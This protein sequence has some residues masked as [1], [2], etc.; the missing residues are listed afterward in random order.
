MASGVPS[1]LN[2]GR[3]PGVSVLNRQATSILLKFAALIWSSG[4]Y[5]VPWASAG[6]CV[7]S[8]LLVVGMPVVWPGGAVV[9]QNTPAPATARTAAALCN[10]FRITP[11]INK[12]RRTRKARRKNPLRSLRALRSTVVALVVTRPRLRCRCRLLRE[13]F[14]EDLN[15]LGHLFHCAE[16][17]AGV[18][19]LERREVARDD[20][21]LGAAGIAERPRGRA[22]VDE[23]EVGL[24]VGRLHAAVV[25]PLR[26]HV[27]HG[28]VAHPLVLAERAVGVLLDRGG[29]RGHAE[30]VERAGAA[31]TD[32]RTHLLDRIGVGDGVALAQ[33]GHAV[34]LREGAR[35][36]H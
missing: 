8:P 26:D 24:R 1:S 16:R 27:A 19:L 4:E 6:E 34:G 35:D 9:V 33:A 2:S 31:R 7:P 13:H 10:V 5:L 21:A 30:H 12:E 15:R 23:H 22:D 14:P 11:P 36:D 3:V 28:L 17:D 25:E 20:D 18:G 29:R 32:P